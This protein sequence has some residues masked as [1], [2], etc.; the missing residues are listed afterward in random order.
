[1]QVVEEWKIVLEKYYFP[2]CVIMRLEYFVHVLTN[3]IS[4]GQYEPE[5]QSK[6]NQR[7]MQ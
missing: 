1:M 7:R 3:N 4:K 2:I 5:C 6:L